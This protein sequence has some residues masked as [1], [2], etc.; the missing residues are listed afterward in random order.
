[1]NVP[2]PEEHHVVKHKGK[3][4]AVVIPWAEYL[5][6]VPPPRTQPTTPHE[7]VEKFLGEGKSLVQSWREYLNLTQEEV[8]RRLGIKQSSYQQTE[9][10]SARPR[11]ATLEKIAAAFGIEASL[12]AWADD[13]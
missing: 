1:M 11:P 9:K 7:V 4:V 2:I 13:E 6:L 5:T 12:L 3:P 8:A 10:K